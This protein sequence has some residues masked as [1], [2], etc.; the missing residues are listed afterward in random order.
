IQPLLKEY[1]LA[2]GEDPEWL[3]RV[4]ENPQNRDS[5]VRH[6]WG[7]ATHMHV[8]FE[9]PTAELTARRSY[10]ILQQAGL[11]GGAKKKRKPATKPRSTRL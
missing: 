6:R 1:A 7:H 2:Q 3:S 8:R 9:N 4:F 11:V 5:I 10:P